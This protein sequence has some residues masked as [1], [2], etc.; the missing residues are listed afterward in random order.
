MKICLVTPAPPGSRH[1]NRVTAARWA[2]L[3]TQLDHE[4]AVSQ[5]WTGEP[6]DVLVALHA[7]RSFP[8]VDRFQRERPGAPLVVALTGT[9]LY[10]DLDTSPEA[11]RSLDL[12]T[13]L[14]ALQAR[15]GER[16]PDRVR[17]KL[18]VIYQSAHAVDAADPPA[19]DKD[20]FE[21]CVLSHLR[22][23]KD[24]LRAAVAAALLPPSSRIRVLHAGAALEPDLAAQARAEQETNPRYRWLGELPREEALRLLARSSLLVLTSRLEG[25][26]NVV[27]EAI[28]ADVPVVSSR[29]DGSIGLLGADYPGY[30][31]VGDARALA[32][33]LF[34]VENDQP[35]YR[36]LKN[37]CSRVKPLVD[38]ARERESW[39][40]LLAELRETAPWTP[41]RRSR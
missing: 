22:H 13:R 10:A 21:V 29:I 25:G 36:E 4:V 16:L 7:R 38:P 41:S 12:A 37:R 18:R 8:S 3:L 24:P 40:G 27:S 31:P 2:D 1:G 32:D 34:H 26:A 17:H 15:A 11:R 30:F 9:D 33:L 14:V 5:E 35:F 28:A 20:A 19:K 6:C 23:V 39:S